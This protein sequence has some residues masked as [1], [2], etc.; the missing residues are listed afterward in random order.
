[1]RTSTKVFAF[2]AGFSLVVAVVYWLVSYEEAGSVLLLS[3]FVAP[4]V[5]GGYLGLQEHRATGPLAED[6]PEASHEEAA[7]EHLGRFH[8]GSGW[9]VVLG[10]G[11][12]TLLMGLVFGLWLALVGAAL[13]AGAVLGLMRESHGSDVGPSDELERLRLGGRGTGG[14]PAVTHRREVAS[15]RRIAALSWFVSAAVG[16]VLG[17]LVAA[18]AS[19]ARSVLRVLRWAGGGGRRGGR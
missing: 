13:C 9:P 6:D 5:I 7:G 15:D 14:R 19:V 4:L 8:A 2:S 12:A 17:V 3:M 16:V 10:V 1:M 18:G 11:S